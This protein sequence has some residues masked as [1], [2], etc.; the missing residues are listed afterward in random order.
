MLTNWFAFLLHKFLKVTCFFDFLCKYQS[1]VDRLFTLSMKSGSLCSLFGLRAAQLDRKQPSCH[2][3]LEFVCL[4]E[5]IQIIGGFA[6][7]HMKNI[8]DIYV[9]RLYGQ[10]L[11]V[12]YSVVLKDI[13]FTCCCFKL[14]YRFI[15]C[16]EWGKSNEQLG[17]S[18]AYFS[19][20]GTFKHKFVS[21]KVN[22]KWHKAN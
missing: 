2:D 18:K 7:S 6:N 8:K 21:Q 5:L 12:Q 10:T 3:Q 22:W 17:S 9:C 14:K 1:H 11:K 13:L 15:S 16:H 20:L 4:Q 19:N